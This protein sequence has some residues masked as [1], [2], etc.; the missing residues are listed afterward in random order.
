MR[1]KKKQVLENWIKNHDC[2]ERE[3]EREEYI[4]REG[5]K[6]IGTE[7]EWG[8]EEKEE[9]EEEEEEE[10]SGQ[11]AKTVGRGRDGSGCGGSGGSSGSGGGRRWLW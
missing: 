3:E 8:D 4:K 6:S 1:N 7:G 11:G 10:E 5:K 9:A 2:R